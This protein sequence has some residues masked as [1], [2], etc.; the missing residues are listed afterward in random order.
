MR[1]FSAPPPKVLYPRRQQRQSAKGAAPGIRPSRPG[2]PGG[3]RK[4]G[5]A[6]G[7]GLLPPQTAIWGR[8]GAAPHPRHR[9]PR[10]SASRPGSVGRPPS[11]EEG[12]RRDPARAHGTFL[13]RAGRPRRRDRCR[14]QGG[15]RGETM[16][17]RSRWLRRPQGLGAAQRRRLQPPLAGCAPRSRRL[18]VAAPPRP[19]PAGP[20][21]RPARASEPGAAAPR[22]GRPGYGGGRGETRP[23]R[24]GGGP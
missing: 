14:R 21:P 3:R 5:N 24:P 22:S 11:D 15:G 1:K 10:I 18:P 12:S 23:P 20:P 19:P 17:T 4:G 13:S 16:G 9:A 7:V 6:L 2:S 8:Q